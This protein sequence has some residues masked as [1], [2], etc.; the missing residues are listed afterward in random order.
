MNQGNNEMLQNDGTLALETSSLAGRPL[1]ASGNGDRGAHNTIVLGLP[2]SCRTNEETLDLLD[3]M[4]VERKPNNVVTA[5]LDFVVRAMKD[6][7]LKRIMYGAPLVTPDGMP[8]VWVGRTMK[9]ALTERV[10]GSDFI[11]MLLERAAK[12]GHSVFFL[13]GREDIGI[14]A[15][16]QCKQKY[17]GLRIAGVYSPPFGTV[18]QMDNAEI[19]A[20]INKAAPDILLVAFGCPKQEYWIALNQ[21]QLNVPVSIGVGATIDFLSGEMPR[22]PRWMRAISAEWLF[23]LLL[24]P[25]RLAKRYAIDVR[26]GLLPL[27]LQTATDAAMRMF[28]AGH[29][30][31]T[32]SALNLKRTT[33]RSQD[34]NEVHV[35][36]LDDAAKHHLKTLASHLDRYIDDSSDALLIDLRSIKGIDSETLSYLVSIDRRMRQQAKHCVFITGR[37]ANIVFSVAKVSDMLTAYSD[38]EAGLEHIRTMGK[39]TLSIVEKKL[40]GNVRTVALSGELTN[41]SAHLLA[42]ATSAFNGN[43]SALLDLSGIRF[44]DTGGLRQLI[45][46]W[47]AGRENGKMISC[48]APKEFHAATLNAPGLKN[49]FLL[50]ADVAEAMAHNNGGSNHHGTST[51]TRGEESK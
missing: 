29:Q 8:L 25:R 13:G 33:M 42:R 27:M 19:V 6:P 30:N 22:A 46:A 5:N 51:K 23:R 12:K 34:G 43:G 26:D 38:K 20:R 4:I 28:G 37:A 48:V 31:G 18:W 1:H 50:F 11:P 41:D 36:T 2:F 24:E 21:L 15:A 16:E 14:K 35:S 44:L 49:T 39:H 40:N 17:P 9:P 45:D 47:N 3:Q 7:V 10:A 32:A